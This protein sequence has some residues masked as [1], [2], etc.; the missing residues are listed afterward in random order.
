MAA[1]RETSLREE[2]IEAEPA[3]IQVIET[4]PSGSLTLGV[5]GYHDAELVSVSPR[6]SVYRAI[7]TA[8]HRTVAVKV[9]HVEAEGTVGRQ[10]RTERRVMSQL[11]GHAGIVPLLDAGETAGGKP[12][13]VMPYYRRASLTRLMGEHGPLAWREAAFLLEAVAVT[14][15][16]IHGRGLVHGNLGPSTI[17]LT[18]FLLPRVTGFGHCQP[19][20]PGSNGTDPSHAADPRTDVAS[21]GSLLQ[22]L[23]GGAPVTDEAGAEAAWSRM[24]RPIAD[25]AAKA[26]AAAAE[27]RPANA[28]AFVTELRRA[29]GEAEAAVGANTRAGIGQETEQ[30][31]TGSGADLS[32]DLGTGTPTTV[33]AMTDDAPPTDGGITPDE[34]TPE[35]ASGSGLAPSAEARYIL[36]LVACIALAVL[37]MVLA[38]IL[39]VS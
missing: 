21:L 13:L 35:Q 5:D 12:Y 15:A 28:A 1:K 25:L 36:A 16:E 30:A 20:D 17:M 37:G 29:V 19:I 10:L 6:A 7:Q 24:P 27:H 9:F 4:T 38:A 32:R 34:T 33:A 22:S 11:T 14:V 23:V 18:D 26:S 31:P 2:W 8:M 3:S 39:A